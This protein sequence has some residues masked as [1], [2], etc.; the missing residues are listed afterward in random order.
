MTP[1]KVIP[2]NIIKENKATPMNAPGASTSKNNI[3]L[4][5]PVLSGRFILTFPAFVAALCLV[6]IAAILFYLLIKLV[7][8]NLI[9]PIRIL[10]LN[11]KESYDHWLM[12]AFSGSFLSDKYLTPENKNNIPT[13]ETPKIVFHVE[14]NLSLRVSENVIRET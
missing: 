13:K 1:I 11:Y 2:S 12:E 3:F 8:N 14:S 7:F 6:T 9:L 4:P 10:F 5:V